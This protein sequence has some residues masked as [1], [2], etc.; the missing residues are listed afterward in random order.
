MAICSCLFIIFFCL[1]FFSCKIDWTFC[2]CYIHSVEHSVQCV[3]LWNLLDLLCRVETLYCWWIVYTVYTLLHSPIVHCYLYIRLTVHIV[4]YSILFTL[5]QTAYC[6]ITTCSIMCFLV[7]TAFCPLWF[8]QH[9]V[10][11]VPTAY[12]ALCYIRCILHSIY[13]TVLHTL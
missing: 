2:F 4:I 3:E 5:V 6:A 10:H 9:T 7:H 12:C 1:F 13:S 11:L 8:K